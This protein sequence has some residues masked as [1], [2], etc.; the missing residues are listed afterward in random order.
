MRNF[1]ICIALSLPALVF[2][3]TEIFSENFESG[4][5]A[6]WTL[7]DNDQRTVHSS[8]SAF[9]PAWISITDIEDAN[10]TVAG[11]TSYFT[12]EGRASRWLITP[13]VT[14]SDY[15]NI[16]QW[17][18]MSHDPSFPDWYMVLISTTGTDIEDFTDTLFRIVNEFTTWTDRE[19]NLSD[20][21]YNDL[22]VH[23]A[24]VNNTNRGFKLY[25]DD[26]SVIVNSSVGIQKNN[27]E[28]VRIYPNP[29]SDYLY[30]KSEVEMTT[31]QLFDSA[32]KMIVLD[33]SS[34]EKVDI[35]H[36]T[37]GIYTIHIT[38]SQGVV[39]K[40]IVKN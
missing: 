37:A 30:I 14:I 2:G 26:V 8:V 29:S 40:K 24:F 32:G 33:F 18:A 38:T 13:P 28:F 6:T 1:V 15:G 11:S 22:T 20:S 39:V 16:L 4:I 25:I 27:N 19:V 23:F 21:G 17:K 10:N 9:Q 3:Q 12:P 5:P 35:Q 31:I 36:L 34:P 7:I